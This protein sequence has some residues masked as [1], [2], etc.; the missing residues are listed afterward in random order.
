MILITSSPSAVGFY[1][2]LG[3]KKIGTTPFVFSPDIKLSIF[4]F[5]MPPPA[6][7]GVKAGQS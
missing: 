3:A 2:R 6:E 1:A 7:D 4:A 5:E